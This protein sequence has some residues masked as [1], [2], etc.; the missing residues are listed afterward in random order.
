VLQES[1][2]VTPAG[3]GGCVTYVRAGASRSTLPSSTSWRT[4]TAMNVFVTLP[5]RTLP[6]VGIGPPPDW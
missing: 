2:T 1:L 6:L 4:S 3:D 5:I